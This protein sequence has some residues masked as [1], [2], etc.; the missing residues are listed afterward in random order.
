[1]PMGHH[2]A[3]NI[4]LITG[5]GQGIGRAIA[6]ACGAEGATV[7]AADLTPP[8][9]TVTDVE[10]AGGKGAAFACDVRDAKLRL[11][12]RRK[13]PTPGTGRPAAESPRP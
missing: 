11:T 10:R 8:L 12:T 4:V 13:V 3:D 9:P 6:L 1:M 2:L 5:A 7:A